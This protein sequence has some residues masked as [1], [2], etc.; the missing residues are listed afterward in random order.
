MEVKKKKNSDQGFLYRFFAGNGDT[1]R[2]GD[3]ETQNSG[4]ANRQVGMGGNMPPLWDETGESTS[5]TDYLAFMSA[6]R[7]C[8]SGICS[9]SITSTVDPA[10][11]PGGYFHFLMNHLETNGSV[12]SSTSQ[13]TNL[14]QSPM[15]QRRCAKN[16]AQNLGQRRRGTRGIGE[17]GT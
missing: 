6:F 11:K 1:V 10:Q 17:I 3:R 13:L 14:N 16:C 8:A 4:Q 2:P 15:E 7:D 9:N 5:H 12:D